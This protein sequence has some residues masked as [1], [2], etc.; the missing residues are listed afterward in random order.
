MKG[1]RNPVA[2]F[3]NEFNKPKTFRNRKKDH[4]KKLADEEV[5]HPVHEP[6]RRR[7]ENLTHRI[8]VDGLG[9]DDE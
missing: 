9:D 2:K 4:K 3:A 5:K 8:I 1:K 6:Y 7:H